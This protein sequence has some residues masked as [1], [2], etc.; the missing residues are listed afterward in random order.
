MRVIIVGAGA[1]GSYL[2]DRLSNEGQDVVL[3]ESDPVRASQLQDE[4]DA[5][6]I[7]GNGAARDV[8]EEAQVDRADLL[9]AVSDNDGANILACRTAS[10]MGVRKTVARVEDPGLRSGLAELGVNVVIDPG[11]SLADELL[12]LVH[13]EG[14]S[15][16]IEFGNGELILTGGFVQPGAPITMGPLY[17]LR[18]TLGQGDWVA[19]AVVRNGETIVAHGPTTIGEGDHV[20]LMVT[21]DREKVA[22]DLLGARPHQIRR[23][24]ILGSTRVARITSAMMV[25]EGFEVAMVEGDHERCRRLAEMQAD[26]LTLCGDPTDPAV[27]TELD[28]GDKDAV[29]ALTGWDEVNILGSLV[30]KAL[31]ASTVVSRVNRM[32][33]V[34][35]LSG[36]G[37][38]ATVSSRIAAANQI[39]R[40]VRRGRIHSVATFTDTDAEA[41]ELEISSTSKAIGKTLEELDLPTGSIVGGIL[42]DG[43]A[44][45]PRGST[46]IRER[47]HLII[48]ALPEVIPEI[49]ALLVE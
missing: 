28:I 9:I 1:V 4:L 29:L 33:Y 35:L 40:F 43:D 37:I 41:I 31:G 8:L 46:S 5:L 38:D 39:L 45:V 42:R 11:T 13:H 49:E 36:V 16:M 15:E 6:V 20:L 48:F 24:I 7:T 21:P 47:D 10:E 3:I 14:L 30:A 26:V 34:G 23:V 17:E 44:L 18:Q 27:L 19:V 32:S 12:T 2:A 22:L 25:K